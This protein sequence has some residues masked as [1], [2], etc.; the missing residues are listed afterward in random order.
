ML[1]GCYYSMSLFRGCVTRPLLRLQRGTRGGFFSIFSIFGTVLSAQTA[2][3]FSL[4]FSMWI[5]F[6]RQTTQYQVFSTDVCNLEHTSGLAIKELPET[7]FWQCQKFRVTSS[8]LET[9]CER[10]QRVQS[11]CS[12]VGHI[13][14][15]FLFV[16]DTWMNSVFTFFIFASGGTDGWCIPHTDDVLV[17]L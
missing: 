15:L 9:C 16:W 12:Y 8:Q 5:H 11:K 2:H 6:A 3:W 14:L 17:A 13:P 10:L 4:F 1:P 7:S